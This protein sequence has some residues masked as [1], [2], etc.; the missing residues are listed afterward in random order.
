MNHFKHN[1]SE[2]L[3]LS[4][5]NIRF[6]I[7]E[8]VEFELVPMKVKD[9]LF[10]EDLSWLIGFLQQDI[11][12]ISKK[13][14]DLPIKTHYEFLIMILSLKDHSE[15][16]KNLIQT[17]KR[18]MKVIIPEFDTTSKFMLVN[19]TFLDEELF[20]EI[21]LIIFKIMGIRKTIIKST[22]DEFTR[23]EKEIKIR[24]EKI[25]AKGKK[26][27]KKQSFEDMIAAIIYEYPQY[28]IEDVFEL[29][30]H[31]FYY[32]FKYIGKIAN[33]EVSKIAA[34]NG[35]SKKHKYFIE[36]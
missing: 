21:V 34:G 25:R 27:G 32:L 11:K 20:E 29:N 9:I 17:F 31:T 13:S 36:K 35:L 30:I 24:A 14:G 28:K 15:D 5:Q 19:K 8:K 12:D 10:N 16:A 3:L 22:D 26:Q 1:F 33:Y 6:V 18:A 23:R 4:N 2:L 7:K